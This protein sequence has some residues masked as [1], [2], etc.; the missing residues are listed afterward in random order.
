MEAAVATPVDQLSVD[1]IAVRYKVV[2]FG[3]AERIDGFQIENQDVKYAT[4][5]KTILI[6][7]EGGLGLVLGEYQK[8]KGL[9]GLVLVEEAKTKAADAGFLP[10]DAL[11]N[12]EAVV[13]GVVE[14]IPQGKIR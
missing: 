6:N 4:E 2:K 13:D 11:M 14:G 5:M 7:R 3:Q 8:I 9:G 10:G 1:D 12:I